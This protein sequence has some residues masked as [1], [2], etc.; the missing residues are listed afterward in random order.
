MIERPYR[1]GATN[2]RTPSRINQPFA[3]PLIVIDF[4]A[5]ALTLESYP[6]EVGIAVSSGP[7]AKIEVWS[8]LIAPH[9]S[10]NLDDQWDPDAEKLHGISRR[11][12]RNGAPPSDVMKHLNDMTGVADRVWCD[13]GRYDSYWLHQLATTAR[14][15]S[16]F[17]LCDIGSAMT[18]DPR[19]RKFYVEHLCR[20][21]APHRAGPDAKRICAALVEAVR[22]CCG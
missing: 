8:S 22:R 9:P 21:I 6:I 15:A 19:L 1:Q 13:G 4:E 17:A 3:F 14:V 16:C 11:Q 18:A 10:W 2:G 7:R 12:L 20:S 5:T